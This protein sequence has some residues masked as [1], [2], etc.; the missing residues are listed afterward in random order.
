[1]GF[2]LCAGLKPD[3]EQRNKF[4]FKKRPRIKTIANCIPPPAQGLSTSVLRHDAML[5]R[6]LLLEIVQSPALFPL[7][8]LSFLEQYTR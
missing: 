2:A 3:F 5:Y 1:M 4:F 8:A 6:T 7:G